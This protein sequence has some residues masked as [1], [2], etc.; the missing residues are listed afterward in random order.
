[1]KLNH[2]I[3]DWVK[4]VHRHCYVFYHYY[5]HLTDSIANCLMD[6]VA[7]NYWI[8]HSTHEDIDRFHFHIEDF[9]NSSLYDVLIDLEIVLKHL[10]NRK[11]IDNHRLYF[12]GCSTNLLKLMNQWITYVFY[13]TIKFHHNK[14]KKEIHINILYILCAHDMWID[15]NNNNENDKLY[16][17]IER[18]IILP[19]WIENFQIEHALDWFYW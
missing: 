15:E 17:Q 16:T 5:C 13:H 3:R 9:V 8:V 10:D 11:L 2:R 7:Q 14:K 4:I 6:L 19:K 18:N 12:R 1:M